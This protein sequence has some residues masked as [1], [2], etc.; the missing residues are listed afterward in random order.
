MATW[1]VHKLPTV[2]PLVRALEQ[3]T[4]VSVVTFLR[5]GMDRSY[6]DLSAFHVGYIGVCVPKT[7]N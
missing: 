5:D 1:K 2:Q 4:Q 6:I 7:R 3:V